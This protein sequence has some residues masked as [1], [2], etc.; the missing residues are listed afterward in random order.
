MTGVKLGDRLLVIGCGQA[1]LVAQLA[2]KPGLT[3]RACAL[4][5][6]AAMSAR[7]AETALR[8]G[9]L[10][11]SETAP[12][13]NLPHNDSAFDI[14]VL[15]HTLGEIPRERRMAVLTEARRV[16]RDGG[17]CIAIEPVAPRGAGSLVGRVRARHGE[18]SRSALTSRRLSCGQDARGTRRNGVHRRAPDED[19]TARPFW[20][21]TVSRGIH[22]GRAPPNRFPRERPKN[23]ARAPAQAV[24]STAGFLPLGAGRLKPAS[25]AGLYTN[26]QIRIRVGRSVHGS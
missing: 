5:E 16:L 7:A 23:D 22:P 10:L 17:R 4:D 24:K 11:E 19:K 21:S 18:T 2:L 3:G 9:A 1:K 15:N 26:V 13:T 20:T 25:T 12:Y 14:V 8:E 6:N